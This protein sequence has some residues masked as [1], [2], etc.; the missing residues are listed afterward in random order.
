MNRPWFA[1]KPKRQVSSCDRRK[2]FA[3]Y[4]LTIDSNFSA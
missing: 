4:M 3:A 2:E 1:S